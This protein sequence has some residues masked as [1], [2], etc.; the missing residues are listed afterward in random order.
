MFS[1]IYTNTTKPVLQ[2]FYLFITYVLVRFSL[3]FRMYWCD[4]MTQW[5]SHGGGGG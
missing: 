2:L 5:R 4:C 1:S 3:M